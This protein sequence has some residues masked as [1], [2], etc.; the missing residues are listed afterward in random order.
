[1]LQ[2]GF[3]SKCVWLNDLVLN[4]MKE[5]SMIKRSLDIF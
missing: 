4:R 3:E 1:M 2:T 5:L